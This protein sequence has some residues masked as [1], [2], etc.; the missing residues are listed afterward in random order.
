MNR[1]LV[2][3][4]LAALAALSSVGPA[5]YAQ[6][7]GGP[8]FMTLLNPVPGEHPGKIEVIEFFSYGCG[9]CRNFEPLLDAWAGKLPDDVAF[10]KVPITFNRQEWTV[11]ARLYYALEAMGAK[12]VH[13]AAFEAI[14]ARNVALHVE[15][16]LFD[17]VATQGLERKQFIDTYKSFGVQSR[18]QRAAQIAAAYKVNGVPL[19]AVDGRF[20][21]TAST[22]GGYDAMLRTVDELLV[23]ARSDKNPKR[24]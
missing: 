11:L 23:R 22:A 7:A 9:H 8:A 16:T 24:G 10:S 18:M 14:H 5:A 3:K 4:Q 17:W 13:A 12:K 19:M 20:M 21:V 2:L 1:R 6:R 15:S